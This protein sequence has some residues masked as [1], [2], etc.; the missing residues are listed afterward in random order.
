MSFPRKASTPQPPPSRSGPSAR[1]ARAESPSL[2]SR[3]Q[4][5][6]DRQPKGHQPE[7]N[8]RAPLPPSSHNGG[9][10]RQAAPFQAAWEADNPAMAGPSSEGSLTW[11]HPQAVSEGME[12]SSP[13]D[14]SKAATPVAAPPRASVPTAGPPSS[15]ADAAD[16][17]V[18]QRVYYR[19]PDGTV[20]DPDAFVREFSLGSS[21][22]SAP[23][24]STNPPHHGPS[25]PP[26]A[27]KPYPVDT[28]FTTYS[29][30]AV[31]EAALSR[32]S[33]LDMCSGA[34]SVA[35]RPPVQCSLAV[36]DRTSARGR[37]EADDA[38]PPS[39]PKSARAPQQR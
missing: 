8:G 10:Q 28:P 15:D 9:A 31:S 32:R 37:G 16:P 20:L 26:P 30:S 18:L 33:S 6:G 17:S 2:A 1:P 22:P 29:A 27:R 35:T 12:C 7:L 39:P 38:A 23:P 11:H 21:Q 4:V 19:L 5:G 24:V 13:Y 14:A 36:T 25:R 3:R 34:G